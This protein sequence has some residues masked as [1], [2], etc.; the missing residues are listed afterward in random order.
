LADESGDP[1]GLD[2]TWGL[3]RQIP[4]TKRAAREPPLM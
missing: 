1:T 2:R 4:Q 3:K